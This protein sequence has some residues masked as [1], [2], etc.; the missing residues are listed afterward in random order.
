MLYHLPVS[1]LFPGESLLSSHV[2]GF[3]SC[4]YGISPSPAVPAQPW[5][6]LQYTIE[7]FFSSATPLAFGRH[8]LG[9]CKGSDCFIVIILIFLVLTPAFSRFF[10]LEEGL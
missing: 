5:R 7:G 4:P 3:Q 9:L 1:F 2:L 8:C 10:V 6:A